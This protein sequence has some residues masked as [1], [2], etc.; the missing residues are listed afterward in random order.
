MLINGILTNT[1]IWYNLSKS[2]IEEL[3][4]VD[5]LLFRRLMEVPLTTPSESFYLELGVLPISVIIKSRRINYLQKILKKEKKGMLHSFFLTQWYNPSKGDWT[6]QVGQ[7]LRDL[8]VSCT[9][10]EMEAKSEDAFK[11]HVKIKAKEYALKMLK[12]KQDRHSKMENLKYSEI[13]MKSY[14]K[15]DRIS[16]SQKRTI[17]KFRTRMERFGENY[18][19]GS[20]RAMCPLCHLHYDNQEMSLMCPEIRSEIKIDDEIKNI[21]EDTIEENIIHTI[22]KI[23]EVRTKRLEKK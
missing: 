21:F 18:R 1:E 5:R 3:E 23:M 12:T 14:L 22:T 2:E 20:T 4:N 16:V 11:N 7:D 10:E 19:A 15:S 17:F 8:E 9:F 6:E 13:T